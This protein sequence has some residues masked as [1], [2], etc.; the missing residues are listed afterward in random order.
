[1]KGAFVETYKIVTGFNELEHVSMAKEA[2]AMAYSF[3]IRH[4]TFK[5]EMKIH[6]FTQRMGKLEFSTPGETLSLS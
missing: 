6:F 2:R 3:K 1:M 5:T 4:R